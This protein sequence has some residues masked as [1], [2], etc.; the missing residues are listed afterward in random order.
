[1]SLSVRVTQLPPDCP[2]RVDEIRDMVSLFYENESGHVSVYGRMKS[3]VR[4][5]RRTRGLCVTEQPG[6]HEIFMNFD[7]IKESWKKKE[8]TGGTLWVP[9]LKIAAGMVLAHEVQHANQYL[10]HEGGRNSFFGKRRSRY[11]TRPSEV[12]ARRFADEKINEIAAV[13]DVKLEMSSVHRVSDLDAELECIIDDLC[14]FEELEM[15]DL[16]EELRDAGMYNSINLNEVRKRL[17]NSGVV[18][19]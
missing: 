17:V 15:S 7:L 1:M 19:R 14:E 4:D 13:L 2:L 11:K 10:H 9:D 18:I 6:V 12:E 8:G 16:I 3:D 5:K